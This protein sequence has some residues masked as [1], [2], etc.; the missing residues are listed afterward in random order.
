MTYDFG[1]DLKSFN[2]AQVCQIKAMF[3]AEDCALQI[4]ENLYT[5]NVSS[6]QFELPLCELLQSLTNYQN[7][8]QN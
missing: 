3:A 6:S 5:V 2:T 8:S 4:S 1:D 7:A